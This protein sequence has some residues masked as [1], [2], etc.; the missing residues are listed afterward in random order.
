M[1]LQ[2][3]KVI[4]DLFIVIILEVV[5]DFNGMV[6]D[7]IFKDLMFNG[8]LDGGIGYISY[9]F[10]KFYEGGFYF[11]EVNFN[12]FVSGEIIEFGLDIDLVSIKGGSFLGLNEFG[13]VFGLEISGVKVIVIFDIG[14]EW[15]VELMSGENDSEGDFKNVV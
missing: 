5:F 11:L 2:I 7:V 14:E 12:D 15:E 3:I 10:G 6:G 1:G 8:G 13:S 9:N 4:I